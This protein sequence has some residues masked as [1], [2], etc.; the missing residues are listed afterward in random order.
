MKRL[1]VFGACGISQHLDFL[2][3]SISIFLSL[4]FFFI[5]SLVDHFIAFLLHG[6]LAG[7]LS[8][9]GTNVLAVD[10]FPKCYLA[11]CV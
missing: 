4:P 1:S 11:F 7:Q 2:C 6:I 8:R 10:F 5:Y 3:E 9:K